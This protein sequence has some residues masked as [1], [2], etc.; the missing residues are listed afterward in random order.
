[1][2]NPAQILAAALVTLSFS[3]SVYADSPKITVG[4][5]IDDGYCIASGVCIA[6][7]PFHKYDFTVAWSKGWSVHAWLGVEQGNPFEL[8]LDL[9]KWW[10][11]GKNDRWSLKTELSVFHFRPFEEVDGGDVF[12]PELRLQY[13]ISDRT[14]VYGAAEGIFFLGDGPGNG[15]VA[16][17]GAAT[18]Q[19]IWKR[20]DLSLDGRIGYDAAAGRSRPYFKLV[21][22]PTI[23]LGPSTTLAVSGA[24]LWVNPDTTE[25]VWNIA[26]ISHTF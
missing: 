4:A 13:A 23:R 16:Y 9:T 22:T 17:V 21:A 10:R 6:D 3:S 1:M 5:G 12:S 14:Y 24:T 18:T 20:L 26:R 25:A 19:N 7:G 2:R 11:F 8:D 15:V